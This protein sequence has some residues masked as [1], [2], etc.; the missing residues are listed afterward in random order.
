MG[1]KP[2][3]RVRSLAFVLSINIIILAELLVEN[4][5]DRENWFLFP[6]QPKKQKQKEKDKFQVK[7]T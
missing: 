2:G 3:G 1:G 4:G 7:M 6:P 5:R